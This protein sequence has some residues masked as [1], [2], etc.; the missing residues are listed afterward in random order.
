MYSGFQISYLTILFLISSFSIYLFFK[1]GGKQQEFLCIYLGISFI[2]EILM[3]AFQIYCGS[4]SQF[5]FLYNI[6]IFL[7]SLFFLFYYNKYQ[8]RDMIRINVIVNLLF[9]FVF[10]IFIL[11]NYKEVNQVIGVSFSLIY[12]LYSLIWFY[13]KLRYPNEKKIVN[14]PKFWVS[15]GLL[16]WGVFFILRIIPRYLFNEKDNETLI[17]SQSF[18]FLINIFFYLTFFISL[19]QYNKSYDDVRKLK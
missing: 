12:I 11:E 16:F 17:I 10:F 7:C 9:N 1:K 13:G 5:G 8:H 3:F 14:D 4:S 18:F 6:Y 2:L 19:V 15:V